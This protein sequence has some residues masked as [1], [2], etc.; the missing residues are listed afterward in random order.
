M[1]WII[2]S[3]R[4][5]DRAPIARKH[6]GPYYG[7]ALRRVLAAEPDEAR[8][9]WRGVVIGVVVVVFLSALIVLR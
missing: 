6:E 2:D 8:E 4:P 3:H 1:T 7:Y 9:L 5:V